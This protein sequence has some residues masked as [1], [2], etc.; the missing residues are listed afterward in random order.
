MDVMQDTNR[1]FTIHPNQALYLLPQR[2]NCAKQFT[3]GSRGKSSAEAIKKIYYTIHRE[4]QKKI[5]V[6]YC[7]MKVVFMTFEMC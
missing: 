3:V 6:L 4:A 5:P 7:A 2:S 1:I